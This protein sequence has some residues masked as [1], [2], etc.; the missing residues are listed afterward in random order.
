MIILQN[1]MERGTE[2][3]VE[4]DS[5]LFFDSVATSGGGLE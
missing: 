1:I 3:E 5:R 4:Q 2:A